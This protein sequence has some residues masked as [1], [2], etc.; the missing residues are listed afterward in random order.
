M[1]VASAQVKSALLLAGLFARGTT[2]VREP[3]PSRNHTELMLGRFGVPVS[4]RAG[5]VAVEGGGTLEGTSFTVPGDIS[6][7][8][9]FLVAGAVVPEAKV[10][11]EGI[12]I[13]P[14]RTGLVE[15]LRKMGASILEFNRRESGGEPVADLLVRGGRPLRGVTVHGAM[16]PRLIDELPVLAVAAACAA[17]IT[18]IRDAA[19]LRVKEADRIAALAAELRKLGVALEERPDGMRI[20][21]GRTLE[22]AVV[23]S[24]G[25][26]RIAMALAVAGLAA[27]GRTVV[28]G[29][30]AVRISYPQFAADLEGL[31]YAG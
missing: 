15:L 5:R 1:P 31:F 7:A 11:L 28:R 19:E 14:T 2:V 22:G 25:D 26:H 13:N 4:V 9:F 10:L 21:G 20:S 17:G 30:E 6:A 24:H 8:A 3:C 16:I 27:R 12:G 23:E 18:E 29:A